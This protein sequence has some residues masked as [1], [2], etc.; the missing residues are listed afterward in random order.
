[1]GLF[2]AAHG[3]WEQKSPPSLKSFTHYLKKIQ[4]IYE[5]R[6]K[7]F[8]FCW[9]QHVFTGKQQHRIGDTE[10]NFSVIK[11]ISKQLHSQKQ[12]KQ[13][14]CFYFPE[15]LWLLA[16]HKGRVLRAE[17]WGPYNRTA[18]WMLAKSNNF[19]FFSFDMVPKYIYLE[20]MRRKH[21]LN[22][23]KFFTFWRLKKYSKFYGNL[24]PLFARSRY[25]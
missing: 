6:D 18:G 15:I 19:A 12:V 2:R 4:K 24:K 11:F 21:C 16:E 3:W 9:H 14:T 23:P 22:Q 17:G 25:S 8:Q 1:M 13:A 7:P 5:S 20:N 10:L